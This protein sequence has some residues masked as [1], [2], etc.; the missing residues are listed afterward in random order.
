[1]TAGAMEATRATLPSDDVVEGLLAA[2]VGF[3]AGVPDSLLK[4]L[5]AGLAERLDDA[6]HVI[7]ANEGSA[8]ALAAGYHLATG[9]L[10]A[11][12]MQNSGIGNA[13]NPLLSLTDPDVYAIPLLLLIGWRG[14]SGQPDEPQHIKQGRICLPLLE[15]HVA[16]GARADLGRPTTSPREN[17]KEFICRFA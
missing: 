12:Y 14:Q 11:V 13:V 8:V 17:K 1:M 5:C 3:F 6:V 10:G 4:D 9:G 16:R 7:A 2:G 15:I